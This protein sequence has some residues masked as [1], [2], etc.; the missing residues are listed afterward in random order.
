[1][2]G[3]ECESDCSL[4]ASPPSSILPSHASSA[5]STAAGRQ[6]FSSSI[7]CSVSS[8]VSRATEASRSPSSNGKVSFQEMPESFLGEKKGGGKKGVT[9]KKGRASSARQSFHKSILHSVIATERRA[10]KNVMDLQQQSVAS[11]IVPPMR[12]LSWTLFFAVLM[13]CLV[14]PL[15]AIVLF[16]GVGIGIKVYRQT[17]AVDFLVNYYTAGATLIGILLF[18]LDSNKWNTKNQV[19]ARRGLSGLSLLLLSLA[20]IFS[21]G[22]FPYGPICMFIL[23]T[24]VWLAISKRILLRRVAFK[25]VVGW[26]PGPLFLLSIVIFVYWLTWTAKG[27]SNN[28]WSVRLRN[29]YAT[30]VGCAPNFDDHPEC[31]RY[32]HGDEED[33]AKKWDRGVLQKSPC[34]EVYNTCLDAFLIWSMPLFVSLY[35][36]FLSHMSVYVRI[37]DLDAAPKGFSRLVMLLVFGL[38]CAASLSASNAATTNAFVAFLLFC[39]LSTAV[40]FIFVHSRESAEE[41]LNPFVTAMTKYFNIYGDWIRGFAVLLCM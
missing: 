16:S 30:Q 9:K 31:K 34:S 38:W 23:G 15:L 11:G 2:E 1:M 21:A 8:E 22:R 32:Y 26:L 27:N 4:D 40:I 28:G 17:K 29:E 5:S 24:P 33:Y 6:E 20:V 35:L 19:L 41:R 7:D 25:D 13:L 3:A 36:F 14:P 39:G 10:I 12:K 18:I 37:D